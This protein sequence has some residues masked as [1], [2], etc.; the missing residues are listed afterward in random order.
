[1]DTRLKHILDR[2]KHM[3]K[4]KSAPAKVNIAT[5][6][7][8]HRKDWILKFFGDD[9]PISFDELDISKLSTYCWGCKTE[10]N[11]LQRCHL[12]P[13]EK[14]GSMSPFNLV[15]LCRNCHREAPSVSFSEEPMLNWIANRPSEV[16]A[17]HIRF[18]RIL[19][20]TGIREIE[21][22]PEDFNLKLLQICKDYVGT[23]NGVI[24]N[25]TWA[26]ILNYAIDHQNH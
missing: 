18:Q 8:N 16:S 6:W 3:T 21:N 9:S 11:N 1:M 23:H 7:M 10:T 24:S 5:F 15:L 14:D 2:I 13:R 19:A 17:L 12:I 22:I 26:S 25:S 20:L 4:R